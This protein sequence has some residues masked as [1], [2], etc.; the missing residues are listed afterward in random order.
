MSDFV[1]GNR[2]GLLRTGAEYFPALEAACDAAAREIYLETYIFKTIP[3]VNAL[4]RRCRAPRGAALP[5][6]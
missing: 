4:P 6:R 1:H 2:I 3:P 5:C